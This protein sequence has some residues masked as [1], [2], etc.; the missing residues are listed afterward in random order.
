M[1][2]LYEI[3]GVDPSVKTTTLR[4][5]Y[6]RL[7][8]E[9]HPDVSGNP[10]AHERMAQINAAFETL[11]DPVKRKEYDCVLH[12]YRDSGRV[13]QRKVHDQV[14]VKLLKRLSDHRTPIYSISFEPDTDRMVTSS[15]D[16]QILWWDE[17]FTVRR[18]LRLEG[19]VVNIVHPVGDDKVVAAGC[20]ESLISTWQ[21]NKGEV[22][23]WRNTPLEWICCV[24]IAPNGSKVA[25][26]SLHSNVQVCKV[27]TGDSAYGGG[28]HEESVTAVQWSPDGRFLAT[29]SAD[30]TVKIWSAVTGKL[31]H[32]LQNVRSTVTA[33]SWANDSDHLAVAAVDR[34]IRVFKMSDPN[35]VK[36]FFGHDR[37]IESVAFHPDGHLLASVGRDGIVYLWS[38][39]QG[40]GHGKIE[41]SNQPLS[42]VAFSRSGD[43]L[44]AAGLD[45]VVRVWELSFS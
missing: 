21:I 24:D 5:A 14:S 15:F 9:Y 18:T 44:A 23:S 37:P 8:R 29:G 34:S 16:N 30:A 31:L 41:A 17:D 6:R 43:L 42:T 39:L 13:A 1:A 36:T 22:A 38:V 12:G 19:G 28:R 45:K 26:G 3:L 40:R 4:N 11:N 10:D 27:S 2:S 35:T 20:S 33:L 7:V 32:T 25:L